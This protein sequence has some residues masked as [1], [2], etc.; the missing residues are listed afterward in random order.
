MTKQVAA[1]RYFEDFERGM[2]G[3]AQSHWPVCATAAAAWLLA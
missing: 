3:L 2:V 1:A